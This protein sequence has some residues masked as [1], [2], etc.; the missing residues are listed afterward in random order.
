MPSTRDDFRSV[1]AAVG[2]GAC[3]DNR[4]VIVA[5]VNSAEAVR[6]ARRAARM[7]QRDLAAASGIQQPA[8]ARI[9]RGF[10]TPRVD[11]LARLLGACG[12]DLEVVR[13]PGLGVDHTVIR[14]LLDLSPRERLDLAV[15]EARALERLLEAAG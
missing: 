4:D 14:E 3:V 6:E 7:S 13:R 12:H 8:I 10:V 1:L 11:T 15:D 2:A 9:E 5:V